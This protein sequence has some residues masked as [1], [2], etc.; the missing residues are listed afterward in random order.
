MRKANSIFFVNY[1][2]DITK[3]LTISSLALDLFHNKY[4]K[5]NIPLIANTLLYK[6]IKEAYYGGITEV[7]KPYGENLFY[8]DVNSLYPYVAL[9]PLPGL[10]CSRCVYM[11]S[12]VDIN[13]L[14]GFFYCEISVKNIYL[15]LLPVI[16]NKGNIY[17]EGKWEGWYF[18][19]ELKFA[20]K[21]G[22]DVKVLK[23]YNFNKELDVFKDY[24]N[25]IYGLKANPINNSQKSIAKSLLN[26]L[27]GRFGISLDKPITEVVRQKKFDTISSMYND[28]Y[29]KQTQWLINSQYVF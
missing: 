24:V 3:G 4:Y 12:Y 6:D 26:N 17:P 10:E 29:Y 11:D 21:N 22:Y 1:G 14:F 16:T 19:E 9:N 23:G 8:Y 25:D 13:K 18:S 5:N 2:V 15:G 28:N 27:L 7:Y 20:A